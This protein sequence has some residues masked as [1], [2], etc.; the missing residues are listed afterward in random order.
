MTL[1][2]KLQTP[3][4]VTIVS[5]IIG[6]GLASFFR[7]TCVGGNCVVITGPNPDVIAANTYKI[8]KT[9]YK[10]VPYSTKCDASTN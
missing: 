9:C 7:A 8:D 5:V 1:V 4:G 2:D 10:Y 6:L 3:I